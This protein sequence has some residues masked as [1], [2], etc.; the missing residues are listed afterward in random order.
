MCTPLLCSAV[1]V[2]VHPTLPLDPV[3]C[4][5][6]LCPPS[7]MCCAVSCFAAAGALPWKELMREF[8][9]PLE[10]AMSAA[11]GVSTSEV[12]GDAQVTWLLCC[13]VDVTVS[14]RLQRWRI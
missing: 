2:H 9:G 3:S 4:F 12:R 13:D 14:I 8:W 5:S 7:T 11:Q 1:V 6:V 10:Q